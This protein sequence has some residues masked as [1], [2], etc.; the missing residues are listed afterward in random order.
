MKKQI[1]Y[2]FLCLA[3]FFLC[4]SCKTKVANFDGRWYGN[5]YQADVNESWDISFI[6]DKK[7][8]SYLI[9]YPSLSCNG[10][11]KLIKSDKERL[12]FVETIQTGKNICNDKG[13]VVL[14]EIGNDSI[15][16][17]YFWPTRQILN[18]SGILKKE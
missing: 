7:N 4:F 17:Y 11:W 1:L 12:E 15:S 5:A 10:Y 8:N 9:N 2:I 16:F 13:Y 6:S 14:K 3:F 18:A